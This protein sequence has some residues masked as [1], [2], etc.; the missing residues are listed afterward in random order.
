M[1]FFSCK[2]QLDARLTKWAI[3]ATGL[4]IFAATLAGCEKK[5][6]PKGKAARQVYVVTVH[7]KS[8]E[9]QVNLP[10]RVNS[11]QIAEIRPQATGILWKRMF[12]EGADVKKGQQLYQ[13]D[14]RPYQTAYENAQAQLVHDEALYTTQH[15]RAQR[16]GPLKNISAVSLQDYNDAVA[17]EKQTKANIVND[18]A[19]VRRAQIDLDYTKVFSPISGRISR[20]VATQGALVTANQTDPIA[21]VTQLDPIY[22]DIN[23][24]TVEQLRIRQRLQQDKLD[25]INGKSAVKVTLYL[26]DGSQ[27]PLQGE[28]LFS[29]VIVDQQVG[30]VVQRVLFPNPNKLLLPGMYVR[31]V[32][33]EGKEDNTFEVPAEGVMRDLADTPYVY[34]VGKGNKVVRKVINL[35]R[36]E[37][38]NW[39]VV[40][41]I[42]DGDRVIVSDPSSLITGDTV[43]PEEG[44][45]KLGFV[46]K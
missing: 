38:E 44:M 27:Y 11:V 20:S 10:G 35:Q 19:S 42:D 2:R 14:P 29:E 8:T 7:K 1:Q 15:L 32:L 25:K 39:I 31:A 6:P 28:L 18:K 36:Q 12:V 45:N 41:G 46:P 13:I 26:E 17:T 21:T 16:Y 40:G 43:K 9:L 37:G 4:S 3:L 22:V 30:T 5:A 24:P 33:H 23:E 34:V